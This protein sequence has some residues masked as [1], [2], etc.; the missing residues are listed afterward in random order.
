MKRKDYIGFA[1]K[2]DFAEIKKQILHLL[3]GNKS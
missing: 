3:F 2:R 1:E